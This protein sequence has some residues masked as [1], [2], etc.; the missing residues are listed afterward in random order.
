M[1]ELPVGWIIVLIA[2]LGAIGALIRHGLGVIFRRNPSSYRVAIT[3]ANILGSL[4]A[5]FTLTLGQPLATVLAAGLWGS[6]TT[7]S[8]IAVWIAE[9]LRN[10]KFASAAAVVTGHLVG[11]LAGVAAGVAVG[12][13]LP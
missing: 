12:V 4:A 11:G 8:T 5:G 2:I 7:F 10:K 13:F 1:I 3:A 6:V 9:D